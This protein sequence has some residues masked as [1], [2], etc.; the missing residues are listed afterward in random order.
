M[1][2]QQQYDYDFI[3]IGSGFGGSVSAMRLA[4]KGY[5]VAVLEKGKRYHTEDFPKTN[6]NLKKS[7]WMPKLGLYGIQVMS[8]FKHVLVLH[9][10]GVGGGS[11][12]YANQLL[13]PPDEVFEKP[14]W[15][16]D[17]WKDKVMPFYKKAQT[18]LGATPSP[19]IGKADKMLRDVGIE[20][21]GEDTFH[22]NDVGVFFGEPDKPVPDPYFNGEGPDRVGCTFCGACMIGCPIGA[23]NTLDKNYLYFAEKMGVTVFPETEVTGVRPLDEGNSGYEVLTKKS[24]GLFPAKKSF[25]TRSVVFSASVLGTVKLLLECKRK[26]LLPNISDQLGNYI[27]T[28]SESILSIDS[29]EKDTN[30]NDQIRA[31]TPMTKHTSNLCAITKARMCCLALLVSCQMVV[32]VSRVCSNPCTTCCYIPCRSCALCGYRDKRR[33]TQSCWLCKR[34]RTTC[35][36]NIRGVGTTWADIA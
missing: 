22:K 33:V 8:L 24:F 17:N 13:I 19:S 27:R 14:E 34:Q 4:E 36:S 32:G 16:Q 7:L 11:L 23:K 1:T 35:G 5:K 6:W 26:E 21:R 12:V 10:S 29:R 18:M 31:F 9:G 30:W 20:L 2:Q 28:N 25:T 15:G 3:V